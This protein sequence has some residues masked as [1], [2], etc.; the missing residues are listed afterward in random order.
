MRGT[1]GPASCS[2]EL[3]VFGGRRQAEAAAG[4]CV[5]QFRK[6]FGERILAGHLTES[7]RRT[8]A[9]SPFVTQVAKSPPDDATGLG[10]QFVPKRTLTSRNP[11]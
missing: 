11:L 5:D 9:A 2:S 7:Q 4:T 1:F 3:G 8:M 10:A 6:I